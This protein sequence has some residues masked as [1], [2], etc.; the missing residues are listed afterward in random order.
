[1]RPIDKVFMRK[2]GTLACR[3]LLVNRQRPRERLPSRPPPMRIAIDVRPLSRHRSGVGYYIHNL[4]SAFSRVADGERFFLFHH[5]PRGLD[6]TP[7]PGSASIVRSP[8]S[9]ES[10]PLGDLWRDYVLPRTLRRL[11]I[12]VFH[13]P[14]FVIPRT[15]RGF[16][17]VVTIHDLVAFLHPAPVPWRYRR[18]RP[19]PSR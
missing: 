6:D 19:G 3:T 1:M 9:H 8:F 12:D 14:A 11:G 16:T 13:G 10:H 7:L 5:D 4:L 2:A 17:S 18:Y 15:K